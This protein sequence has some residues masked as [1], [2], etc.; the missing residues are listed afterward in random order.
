MSTSQKKKFQNFSAYSSYKRNPILIIIMYRKCNRF[1]YKLGYITKAF[2][3]YLKT[4]FK[5]K[6]CQLAL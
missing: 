3:A 1:N 5:I 2:E 4:A 6:N